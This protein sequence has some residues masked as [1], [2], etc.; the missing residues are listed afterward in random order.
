MIFEL[1]SQ[2]F[3]V[4]KKIVTFL[5]LTISTFILTA[6]DWDDKAFE[7]VKNLI[8]SNH[9]IFEASSVLP[10]EGYSRSLV[11]NLNYIKF[12]NEKSEAQ[13]PYFGNYRLS[14]GGGAIIFNDSIEKFRY[15]ENIKKSRINLS[16]DIKNTTEQFNVQLSVGPSAWATVIIKS[17]NRPSISYYGKIKEI[18]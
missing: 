6:Q 14:S 2:I 11:N 8:E 15:S 16:F 9:F 4:I 7:Q 1:I 13:L 3:N 18:D 17:I 12:E 10:R 5:F